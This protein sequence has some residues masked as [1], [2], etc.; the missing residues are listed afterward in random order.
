MKGREKGVRRK[1]M[2]EHAIKLA[3]TRERGEIDR[4]KTVI[5]ER[6]KE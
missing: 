5:R 4:V 6:R 3:L 2:A 1:K